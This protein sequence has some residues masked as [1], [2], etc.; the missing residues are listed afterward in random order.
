MRL[1]LDLRASMTCCG[2]LV[3]SLIGAIASYPNSFKHIK[4]LSPDAIII[5]LEEEPKSNSLNPKTH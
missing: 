4:S 5:S 1:P 3:G 2:K